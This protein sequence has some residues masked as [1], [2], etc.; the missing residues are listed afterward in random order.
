MDY[1]KFI[2]KYAQPVKEA[3]DTSLFQTSLFPKSPFVLTPDQGTSEQSQPWF[4][5]YMRTVKSPAPDVKA[6]Q[7]MLHAVKVDGIYGP[8]TYKLITKWQADHGYHPDGDPQKVFAQIKEKEDKLQT[9]IQESLQKQSPVAKSLENTQKQ[10]TTL[11]VGSTQSS[12]IGEHAGEEKHVL[13]PSVKT[14][15]YQR[16]FKLAEKIMHLCK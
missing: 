8:E 15:K 12:G 3:Q 7:Q 16:L 2:K 4:K 11:P 10:P 1:S 6:I 14:S 13:P 5:Y 9:A